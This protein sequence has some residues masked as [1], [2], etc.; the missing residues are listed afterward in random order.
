MK[1]NKEKHRARDSRT[2][3]E[4]IWSTKQI[5]ATHCNAKLLQGHLQQFVEASPRHQILIDIQL[6]IK[7]QTSK[8]FCSPLVP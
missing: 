8:S 2:S 4:T 1:R 6:D 7:R 5:Y 3:A